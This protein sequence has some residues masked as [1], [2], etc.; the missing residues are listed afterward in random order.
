MGQLASAWRSAK[1][2][3]SSMEL[4]KRQQAR[5]CF[6]LS[7]GCPLLDHLNYQPTLSSTESAMKIQYDSAFKSAL[8]NRTTVYFASEHISWVAAPL[9]RSSEVS[10]SFLIQESNL[11]SK[12]GIL[13]VVLRQDISGKLIL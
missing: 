2:A 4:N 3:A 5:K 7:K 10:F 12:Q 13:P 6:F 8:G 1:A 11:R 9:C